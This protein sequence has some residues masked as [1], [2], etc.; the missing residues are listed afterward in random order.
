MSEAM[1]KS[2]RAGRAKGAALQPRIAPI[3]EAQREIWIACTMDPEVGA[4]Y[5]QGIALDIAGPLDLPAL[6]RAVQA[7]VE[8][9]EA[10]RMSFNGEGT[11]IRVAGALALD[12][13]VQEVAADA[14]D[15]AQ[16]ATMQLAFD[17]EHG[18]LV[19]FRVLRSSATQHRLL[20]VAHHLVHDGWSWQALLDD[21]AELYA[22]VTEG[23][24]PALAEAPR[25]TDH[26]ARERAFLASDAGRA[27][28]AW[29]LAQLRDPPAPLDL[30]S[31]R[32]RPR[33][34]S[35]RAGRVDRRLPDSLVTKLRALASKQGATLA[36]TLLSAL[37]VLLH[38]LTGS[39][40]LLV[41]QPADRQA[42][43]GLVGHCVPL[44]PL[45]LRPDSG[46]GFTDCLARTHA[47]VRNAE[48]HAGITFGALLA[49]LGLARDRSRPPLA[50]VGF[51]LQQLGSLTLGAKL[52]ARWSAL[53]RAVEVFD[54][55]LDV[56]DDGRGL[57]L[58]C[59][60][61]RDLF[62]Q[63]G[64]E[65]RMAELETLLEG[66]VR[67]PGLPL[68][69]LPLLP[70]EERAQVLCDFNRTEAPLP[71]RGLH[72]WVADQCRRTPDQIA[73]RGT[74]G[75]LSYA[76][77]AARS[78]ALAHALRALGAQPG[79]VVGVAL[80]RSTQMPLALQAVHKCGGAYL[81]LD[82]ELPA[83]RL[84]YMVEDARP[85]VLLTQRS[86]VPRLPALDCAVLCI[87]DAALQR[88]APFEAVSGRGELPAYLIYTSGS[89]GRPKGVVVTQASVGNCLR[90]VGRE[91]GLEASDV[92]VAV[93]TLSFDIAACD[94]FLP[95][96]V[97]AR[98]VVADRETC[99]DGE[100]LAGLLARE[101]ASFLQCTPSTWRL[102]LGA[103]W[104]GS[105]RLLGVST[106]EQLPRDLAARLV[107]R[108]KALWNLYGPTETTIW[109]TGCRVLDAAHS[110]TIGRP[111][112]N[113]QCYVLDAE[114]QPTP[115]GV[116]G[117]L[118]I[119]GAGVARGYHQRPELT[120]ERFL[121][122]PFVPGNRMYRTG[123]LARW[124][125]D[126]QLECLGRIDFQVKLR[127][128]R[129]ELGEI[130]AA[131]NAHPAVADSV[132]GV[133]ERTPG[134]ARLAAWI[135]LRPGHE[136]S[137]SDLRTHLR[138]Q[139]PAYMVP[140]HFVPL[141]AL[142]RLPNGKLE[143]ARLPSPFGA[144]AP[145]ADAPAFPPSETEA[146]V[147]RI[148]Q[149]L[150]GHDGVGVDDR[151]LDV[152]GHSLLA[153]QVA[154][155][156]RQAFG[157]RVPLREVMTA[158]LAQVAA[159]CQ[160]GT[161][162]PAGTTPATLL[163]PA[164]APVLRTAEPPR[165]EPAYFGPRR[166]LFGIRSPAAAPARRT[167]VLVCQSWGVE[168]MRSYRATHLLAQQLARRGFDTLRFDYSCTG[169]SM[170]A[171]SSAEL[172]A[173]IEDI[174]H[175]VEELRALSGA[176]QVCVLGLRLGALLAAA[177]AR[178]GGIDRLALWD[179]PASGREWIDQ[180][181]QLNRE[182]YQRKNRY[183]S[184]PMNLQL[185]P[186]ELLGAPWP[187][188][189]S[190]AVAQLGAPPHMPPERLLLLES[191]DT[192]AAEPAPGVRRVRLPDEAHW[193]QIAWLT[194]P[195]APGQAPRTIGE[196]LEQWL[197]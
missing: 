18:P 60:Y 191:A 154:A 20:V 28:Q 19:A 194:T 34:R 173:W 133:R 26:A 97:G 146:R 141:E 144:P 107:P 46:P 33:A 93:S 110:V 96:M 8:R 131:L 1:L 182:H 112:A 188:S 172:S 40:D 16:A 25:Y 192:R 142:P 65:R 197:C 126:A 122:D 49:A 148:W 161:E 180:L 115:V 39:S 80:E 53:P 38:R 9:H 123:D 27:N 5:N 159:A 169:D 190:Q 51:H 64:I 108:L 61:N 41:A 189:L 103:G 71:S 164:P 104:Q 157:V 68:A 178:R 137:A 67:E 114:R 69:R 170:G 181:T 37:G 90:S 47:V 99:L 165:L 106:G 54:L 17:I 92:V 57:E 52:A 77:L 74:D 21:L 50:S 183:L 94:M 166:R 145:A 63:P 187:A 168:Y 119:A 127:G 167:A 24:P 124:L 91:P 113:T 79:S 162:Q 177:A 87:E 59:S 179:L 58:Q 176:E 95:L 151:F 174:G 4:A 31:E 10:L 149:E 135:E 12:V 152:G 155:R 138:S 185:L 13:P 85:V 45:R 86:V 14:A 75:E 105:P 132:C 116:P 129:I 83:E 23:R 147:I 44:L 36:S 62:D 6:V 55:F 30:P 128:Y 158:S 66:I 22:A 156:L 15:A 195:W 84:A 43:A 118:Y 111:L 121:D 42:P 130:E 7:L 136:A 11:A 88:T 186:E 70:P 196:A 2:G 81:P 160:A 76:Q 140:Q 73:L 102:L 134:D 171:G 56:A 143:R 120:A 48:Q 78:D 72:E 32:A 3:T 125:P 101:D 29:W 89:T 175:A 193:T 98:L 153:V 139:L 184:T 150:L 100:K 117:E 163:R 109:S 35:F 82:P